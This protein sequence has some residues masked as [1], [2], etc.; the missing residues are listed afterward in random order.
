MWELIVK[1]QWFMVPLLMCS[2]L[3][4]AVIVERYSALR[5]A[6]GQTQQFLS[7]FDDRV[8]AGDM[9]GARTLCAQHDHALAEMM[10]AGMERSEQL[11][12]EPSVAFVHEQVNHSIEEQG[13]YAVAEL[14]THLGTLASVATIAPLLGFAGTVTGMIRAFDAIAAANDINVGLVA[15]GISEA[16][17]T[18]ASGLL[19]AIPCVVAFNYFTK[20]VESLTLAMEGSANALI[21]VLIDQSRRKGKATTSTESA[22]T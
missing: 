2:V 15:G 11:S 20:Q 3:G 21:R 13:K 18:T 5:K 9:A 19:V 8:K 4:I 16:L 1:G 14:E 12:D 7:A 6:R 22:G 10:L 17:I